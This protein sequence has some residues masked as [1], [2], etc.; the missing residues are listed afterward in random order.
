MVS[1]AAQSDKERKEGLCGKK[2]YSWK[3][4][5]FHPYERGLGWYI[6]FGF[7]TF[8]VA[9]LIYLSDPETSSI[10]V[11]CICLV[12]AF[13]LWVHRD[14]EKEHR[15]A[16]YEKCLQVGDSK[17]ISWKDFQGYWFLED[18][19]SRLLVIEGKSW[20]QDRVRILLGDSNQDRINK[21]MEKV[22]LEYLE[23]RKEGGFDL[24]SRVFRL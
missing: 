7:L 22:G 11:A 14:G 10:P 20:K 8:G 13:Y 24:W 2:L 15:I 21:A 9:L 4:L 1:K 12:A 16:L 17:P 19:H 3:T 23:D 6:S 5:D 18:D